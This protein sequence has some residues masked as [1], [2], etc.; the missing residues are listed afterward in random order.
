MEINHQENGYFLCLILSLS[1]YNIS[2][3]Y[4][5]VN[6]KQ[7]ESQFETT[8][9]LTQAD[10]LHWHWWSC[11]EPSSNMSH[12]LEI[13]CSSRNLGIATSHIF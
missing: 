4:V 13:W 3:F 1:Q 7:T 11:C 6:Q 12:L 10:T 8:S 5:R 9:T 2:I